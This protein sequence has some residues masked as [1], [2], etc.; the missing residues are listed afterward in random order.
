[1]EPMGVLFAF[2]LEW[3]VFLARITS[4]RANGHVD[5]RSW[6]G[7]GCVG[8]NYKPRGERGNGKHERP[9]RHAALVGKDLE[10]LVHHRCFFPSMDRLDC[11]GGCFRL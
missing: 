4:C 1:M 2:L 6:V 5:S 9:M 3:G 8:G 11:D 7:C 10:Q